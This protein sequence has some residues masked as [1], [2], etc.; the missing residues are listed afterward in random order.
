MTIPNTT[1][2]RVQHIPVNGFNPS[3][4]QTDRGCWITYRRQK[5]TYAR[6]LSLDLETAETV[7]L[8]LHQHLDDCRIVPGTR[9][10]LAI[11]SF[12]N[13]PPRQTI[14]VIDF[15]PDQV[16]LL[17]P[18]MPLRLANGGKHADRR[19]EKNWQPFIDH[20]GNMFAL[21]DAHPMVLMSPTQEPQTWK[22]TER[23]PWKLPDWAAKLEKHARL[24]TA[25]IHFTLQTLLW[26][27]HI[28]DAK[29][30]YWTGATI[31]NS[32]FPFKPMATTAR[33]LLTPA[34]AS[35]VSPHWAPNTCVYPMSAD[36]PDAGHVRIWAGDS[37]RT[38]IALTTSAKTL[39]NTFEAT[40]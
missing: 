13:A 33:P 12:W 38:S 17:T 4:F 10:A 21:Y 40:E 8:V 15:R 18:T 31:S 23:I 27:W 19:A 16:S 3:P 29:A 14:A 35:D 24:S 36:R 5:G 7:E 22:I 30:G 39:E 9:P 28:K 37:D 25:P 32:R 1:W 6:G 2:P 20:D 11:A 26:F 34:D